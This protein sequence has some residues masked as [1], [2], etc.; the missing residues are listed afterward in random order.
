MQPT[1]IRTLSTRRAGFTLIEMLVVVGVIATLLGLLLAGLQAAGRT[2]RKTGQLNDL[3]QTYI[4]WAAYAGSYGDYLLPGKIDVTTQGQWRVNYRYQTGG[5][6]PAGSCVHYPFRLMAYLDW[7]FS[8]L[9]GYFPDFDEW[10]PPTNAGEQGIQESTERVAH[11]PAFGYNGFYM[12]GSWTTD[13]TGNTSM[14]FANGEWQMGR[15]ASDT[16]GVAVRGK[17]VARTLGNITQPSLKV[18]FCSSIH[19]SPGIY[20]LSSEFAA[21][22]DMVVPHI[23]A[24]TEIWAPYIGLTGGVDPTVSRG[25]ARTLAAR[26]LGTTR[27]LGASSAPMRM[28]VFQT[29]SVPYNR[30]DSSIAVLHADGN[31]T[32]VSLPDLLDQSRWINCAL[33]GLGRPSTF[34]HTPGP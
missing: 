15:G 29:A 27:T 12:G 11:H 30:F 13:T 6:I 22:S 17:L 2:S 32:N 21:G 7:N 25:A 14:Q 33:D 24:E 4:A 20:K 1:T 18:T 26:T 23:F 8:S 19:R 28:E 9:Y 10:Y 3:R 5:D 31:T 34:S 16:S